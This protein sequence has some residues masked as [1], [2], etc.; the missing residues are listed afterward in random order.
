MMNEQQIAEKM[1]HDMLEIIM[2][3]KTPCDSIMKSREKAKK[4]CEL[5]IKIMI[6]EWNKLKNVLID[7]ALIENNIKFWNDVET[8]IGQIAKPDSKMDPIRDE[9]HA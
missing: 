8:K 9:I 5:M 3:C 6:N 1:F 4:G 7:D 2:T